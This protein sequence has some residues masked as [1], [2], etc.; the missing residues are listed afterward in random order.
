MLGNYVE[1]SFMMEHPGTPFRKL[2]GR[3][4]NGTLSQNLIPLASYKFNL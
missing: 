3:A 2:L 1:G 4:E